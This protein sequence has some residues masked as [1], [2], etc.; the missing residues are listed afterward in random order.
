MKLQSLLSLSTC[1]SPSLSL[2][3]L[4]HSLHYVEMY[5]LICMFI[6]AFL[7]NTFRKVT[8]SKK[9]AMLMKHIIGNH[10]SL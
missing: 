5:L 7:K 3:H 2:K 1:L 10:N 4:Q 9:V 6:F 8:N